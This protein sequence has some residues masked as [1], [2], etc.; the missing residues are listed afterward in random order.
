MSNYFYH[1]PYFLQKFTS[2]T[3]LQTGFVLLSAPLG[4]VIFSRIAGKFMGRFGT[5]LFMSIGLGIMFIA[6]VGLSFIEAQWSP[7]ILASLLFLY[8]IGGGIFQPSNIAS[9]M[10]SVS[11]RKTGIYW[12]YTTHVTKCCNCLWCSSCRNIHEYTKP[13]R[14]RWAYPSFSIFMVYRRGIITL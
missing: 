10:A 9:V 11:K 6:F 8:G 4:L 5:N 1:P 2:L 7:Y 14:N 12:S 3:P 13:F